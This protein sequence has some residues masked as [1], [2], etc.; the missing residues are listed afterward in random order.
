MQCT[1]AEG[2]GAAAEGAA[3]VDTRPTA[4]VDTRPT[5]AVG[6][7][8]AAAEEGTAEVVATVMAAEVGEE[9]TSEDVTSWISSCLSTEGAKND[10]T[11]SRVHLNRN[12][13]H[14]WSKLKLF[15]FIRAWGGLFPQGRQVSNGEVVY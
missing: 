8:G 6:V 2:A 13:E 14:L 15:F 4:A 11:S 12:K 5:A 1:V 9:V 10:P 7:A 3:E